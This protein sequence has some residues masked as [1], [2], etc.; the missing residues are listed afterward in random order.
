MNTP[1]NQRSISRAV[2]AA[3]LLAF[4]A[5]RLGAQ[6]ATTAPDPVYGKAADNKIYAQ[7]LVLQ[8][9][10]ENLDLAGVGLH[11][12]PPG[13]KDYEIVA[14]IRDLIGKKSSPD[15]IEVI[16]RDAVKIYPFVITG[17]PRFSALA[18]LRDTAGNIIGMAALS[19]KREAG[20]DRL[21]V[22]ARLVTIMTQL[23][24]KIPNRDALFKPSP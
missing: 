13:K 14:Q 15:D 8:V 23:A 12:I 22:H 3:A 20:V 18:A 1:N 16:E 19:F 17:S 11:A 5:L 7:Q 2:L 10:A 24:L 21:T 6:T 9:M 4:S